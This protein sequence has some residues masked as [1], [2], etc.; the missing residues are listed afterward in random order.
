MQFL[1]VRRDVALLFP[2]A[3]D[4]DVILQMFARVVDVK[5]M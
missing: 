2:D 3:Y 1:K 4:F 5:V